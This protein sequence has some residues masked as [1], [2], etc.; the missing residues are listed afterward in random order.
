MNSDDNL[1]KEMHFDLYGRY[2]LIHRI[3]SENNT[4][5]NQKVLDVGGRGNILKKFFKD[6]SNYSIYYLDPLVDTND[7]NYI[8]G[9]GC[10]IPLEDNSF[11]WVVST[12]VFE[13]II[14]E[15]RTQFLKENLR[16]AKKGMILAAPFYS[17]E[18]EIAEKDANQFHKN[19]FNE[20]HIFLKEHISNGL[21]HE[22]SV[23]DFISN[24]GLEHVKYNNNSMKVWPFLLGLQS[25][26]DFYKS[27]DIDFDEQFHKFNHFYNEFVFQN[28]FHQNSYRKIYF[29]KKD[30]TLKNIVLNEESIPDLLLFRIYKEFFRFVDHTILSQYESNQL[31][32]N[33]LNE[34]SNQLESLKQ[35]IEQKDYLLNKE[36][37]EIIGKEKELD[38]LKNIIEQK[39]TLLNKGVGEVETL[40]N[41]IEQKDKNLNKQ[42]GEINHLSDE[43]EI[44][45][46]IIEQKDKLIN[47]QVGD[48][49]ELSRL[50]KDVHLMGTSK[51]WK[52]RT[53][54]L[55]VK[56]AIFTPH[57]FLAKYL[58][59]VKKKLNQ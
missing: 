23:I 57:K 56:F 33:N 47:R 49:S 13:H 58:G 26:R 18:V 28:D 16:V 3:I 11:D 7:E 24:Q 39:D 40:K 21:P 30:S 32:R 38:N 31:N 34:Y 10:N 54:Y 6:N 48:L 27:R 1:K 25:I 2:K 9:D 55:K 22:N 14:P 8:E 52:L 42:I 43:L 45:K 15:K 20:D 41:I 5:E 44:H 37:G 36:S 29:I 51:F 12:D 17:K 46:K 19:L 53:Y 35:L 59:R 50:R 4:N